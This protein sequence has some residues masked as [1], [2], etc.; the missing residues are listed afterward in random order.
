MKKVNHISR[1]LGISQCIFTSNGP[2]SSPDYQA[3][4]LCFP[5]KN[6]HSNNLLFNAKKSAS[7]F[8]LSLHPSRREQD[9][10][11]PGKGGLE[12]TKFQ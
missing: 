10:L 9:K 5:K 6:F 1:Y 8:D 7:H 4:S 2:T 12:E 11:R 3:I